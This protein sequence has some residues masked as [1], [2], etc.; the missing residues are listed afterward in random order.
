MKI[1]AE[2]LRS[3]A[4]RTTLV[5][6]LHS[7]EKFRK[8]TTCGVPSRSS[9]DW[10][11]LLVEESRLRSQTSIAS[12]MFFAMCALSSKET[13]DHFTGWDNV[14][15]VIVYCLQLAYVADASNRRAANPTNSL[16][17]RVDG[18]QNLFDLLVKQQ[19]KIAKVRYLTDASESFSFS[20][21]VQRRRQQG[22]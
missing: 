13:P 4:F 18:I 16:R 7:A 21:T 5:C 2:F 17:H 12:R 15:I 10:S 3:A 20:R 22:D 9:I 1:V 11:S 14:V 6:I 19:M 8:G